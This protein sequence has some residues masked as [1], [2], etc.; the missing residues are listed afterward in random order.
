MNYDPNHYDA[1]TGLST[2]TAMA[3]VLSRGGSVRDINW[4]DGQRLQFHDGILM[5]HYTNGE[6]PKPYFIKASDLTERRFD[7][8]FSSMTL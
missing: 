5:T 3:E 6:Q 4:P 7:E 8:V 2:L 1:V